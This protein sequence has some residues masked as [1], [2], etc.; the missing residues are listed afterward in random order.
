MDGSFDVDGDVCADGYG[1][2]VAVEEKNL[3]VDFSLEINQSVED[4]LFITAGSAARTATNEFV[5]EDADAVA[6]TDDGAG[7][8]V[9][10]E[11]G[12]E[13]GEV[14]GEVF[15]GDHRGWRRGRRVES[16]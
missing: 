13:E 3:D 1:V 2:V 12:E 16:E 11:E 8:G 6:C 7:D 15:G 4:E 14:G 5:A 10:R 9:E